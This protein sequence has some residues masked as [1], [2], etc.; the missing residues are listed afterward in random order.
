MFSILYLMIDCIKSFSVIFC[1]FAAKVRK[2]GQNYVFLPQQNRFSVKKWLG[3]LNIAV[4]NVATKPRCTKAEDSSAKRYVPCRVPTAR[5]SRTLWWAVSLQTWHPRTEARSAGFV[6]SVAAS[7]SEYGTDILVPSARAGWSR[8][9]K[10]SFGPKELTE[11][12]SNV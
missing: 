4:R 5:A 12:L 3:N 6:C 2:F 8:L 7:I 10:K 11:F 1:N 9:E